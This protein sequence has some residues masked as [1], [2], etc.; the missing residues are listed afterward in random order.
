MRVAALFVLLAACDPFWGA[1]VTLRD[2]QSSRFI[3]EATVAVACA[4]DSPYAAYA[5]MASRTKTDGTLTVGSLG[6]QWPVGCDLY[7]AKP[8]YVTKRIAYRELC[9]NG[10]KGC[11]RYFEF[12][13]VL[14]PATATSSAAP[15]RSPR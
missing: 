1:K 12:D 2:P 14:E 4:G 7:I 9:P 3:S 13:L 5:S 6:S 15:L 10:P 8:G 11:E